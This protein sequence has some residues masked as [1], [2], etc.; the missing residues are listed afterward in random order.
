MWK[1]IFAWKKGRYEKEKII[2]WEK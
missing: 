2:A 1:R